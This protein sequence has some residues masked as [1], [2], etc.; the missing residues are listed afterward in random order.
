MERRI[1]VIHCPWEHPNNKK[2]FRDLGWWLL[3]T[4]SMAFNAYVSSGSSK[5]YFTIVAIVFVIITVLTAVLV[6]DYYVSSSR[7]L[8][9][10]LRRLGLRKIHFEDD[11]RFTATLLNEKVT[12]RIVREGTYQVSVWVEFDP[13]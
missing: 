11:N 4:I 7:K 12:G 13:K 9:E 3:L 2:S 8:L 10:A 6:G 1:G 5:T